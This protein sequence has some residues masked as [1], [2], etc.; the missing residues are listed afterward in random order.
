MSS[1]IPGNHKHLSLDDRSYIEQGLNDG[2]SFRAIS[3][4]L[5]KDPSTI[6]DKVFKKRIPNTWN[7]G[8]FNNPYNFCI[9]RFR[10][11]KT[12]ACKKSPFCDSFC[13][14]YHV[15]NKVC[16]SFEPELCHINKAPFVCNG[17]DKLRNKCSISLKYEYN[18]KATHRMYSERLVSA[19]QGICLT[20]KELHA[21][22]AVVTPLIHQGLT[23][24]CLSPAIRN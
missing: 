10:C 16:D 8:S 14:Y 11:Q 4:Y 23:H 6:S 24:I 19:R 20:Q 13:R 15:C 17:C 2:K 1:L 3:K 22:D 21:I 9:H 5:C 12:N 18:V 7:K